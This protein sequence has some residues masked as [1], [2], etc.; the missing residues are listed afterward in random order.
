MFEVRGR[1]EDYSNLVKK[2]KKSED[3]GRGMN[4]VCV[5]RIH[6]LF[7]LESSE[8]R[9]GVAGQAKQIEYLGCQ[10]QGFPFALELFVE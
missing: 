6:D 3:I 8:V 5:E 9:S 1:V 10:P 7:M 4:I 2:K